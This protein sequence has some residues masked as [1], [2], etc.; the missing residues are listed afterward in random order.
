MYLLDT[1]TCIGYLNG[2]AIHVLSKMQ[3]T[4]AQEIAVC[5]VVKAELFYGAMKSTQP[6]KVL[7]EQRKFLDQFTSCL[8]MIAQPMNMAVSEHIWRGMAHRSVPTTC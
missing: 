8:S 4:P 3:T 5:S 7:T 6:A 2:T 1:N